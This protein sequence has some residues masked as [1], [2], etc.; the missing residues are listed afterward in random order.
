MYEACIGLLVYLFRA[1]F[2]WIVVYQIFFST[3][4]FLIQHTFIQI[5]LLY[6]LPLESGIFEFDDII[7]LKSESAR[8][9]YCRCLQYLG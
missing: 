8:F 7:Y 6:L 2:G 9:L 5:I 1:K 4:L 3:A